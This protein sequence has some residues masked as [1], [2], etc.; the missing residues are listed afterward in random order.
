MEQLDEAL[1]SS[2]EFARTHP[3]TLVLVT[4]DH[5]QAAQLV[6]FVSLFDAYPVPVYTPGQLARIVT[7]EG[8]TMA[9]NYATTN[10]MLEE[11]TGASVPIYANEAGRDIVPPFLQQPQLFHIM[12]DYL[13]L[14]HSH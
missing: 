1:A 14:N 7:P 12:S 4:A 2:L 13:Q 3:Q 11:H 10:F 9:I 5:S 8:S 6:P